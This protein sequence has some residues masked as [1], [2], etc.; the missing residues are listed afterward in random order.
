VDGALLD[1]I[2]R[3]DTTFWDFDGVLADTEPLQLRAYQLLLEEDG[4]VLSESMFAG[5]VGNPERVIWEQ[6]WAQGVGRRGPLQ[7]LAERRADV[8]LDLG[9]HLPAG[10]T[11]VDLGCGAAAGGERLVLSS[12]RERVIRALLAR[13]GLDREFAA[14]HALADDPEPKAERL[15]RLVA[16]RRATASRWRGAIVEDSPAMLAEGAALGLVTVAVA[17]GLND[18]EALTAADFLLG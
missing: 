7:E 17:H 16:D 5:L 8:F 3:A 18:P 13:W 9:P 6:L 14:V 2:G 11:V 10:A 12:G 4:F 15:R 1:A